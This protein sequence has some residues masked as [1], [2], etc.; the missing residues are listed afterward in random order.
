MEEDYKLVGNDGLFQEYLEMGQ[1]TITLPSFQ[2]VFTVLQFGFITIFVAAFPLAPLF[3]LLNNWVEIRLDAQKF[4]CETRRAVAE[5][6]ENI[7]IW[8]TIMDM[9]AQLAVISNV[10][11]VIISSFHLLLFSRH[12]SLHSPVTSSRSLST[13]FTMAVALW[14]GMLTSHCPGLQYLTG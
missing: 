9:L 3:A 13:E 12:F 14:M 7:G 4:V 1:E 10:S 11:L 5:R 2:L 8:F 6:A